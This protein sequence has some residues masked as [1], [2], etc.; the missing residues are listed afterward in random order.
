MKYLKAVAGTA[1]ALAL[2]FGGA[3]AAQAADAPSRSI[4]QVR[5]SQA[6]LALKDALAAKAAPA[7]PAPANAQAGKR[8]EA[9]DV[10]TNF[11]RKVSEQRSSILANMR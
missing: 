7:A 1:A 9:Y 11:A 10:M 2:V 5:S 6:A 4:E 8:A 3:T